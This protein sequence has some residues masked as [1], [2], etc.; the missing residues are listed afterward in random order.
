[1]KKH[2]FYFNEATG[3]PKLQF[4]IQQNDIR[5][6]KCNII[7]SLQQAITITIGAEPS[8]G[9]IHLDTHINIY[10]ILLLV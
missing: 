6:D 1:L 5:L 4:N 7:L 3:I 8:Q 10:N 2:L 9:Q